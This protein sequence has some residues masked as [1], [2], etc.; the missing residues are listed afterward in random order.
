MASTEKCARSV[1]FCGFSRILPII[2]RRIFEDN[3]TDH[4]I[5]EEEQ[6]VLMD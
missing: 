4:K 1:E 3:K 6:E 5:V 2:C